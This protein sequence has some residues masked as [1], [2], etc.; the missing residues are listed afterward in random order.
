MKISANNLP[1]QTRNIALS[2]GVTRLL[3]VN[4]KLETLLGELELKSV[5]ESQLLGNARAALSPILEKLNGELVRLSGLASISQPGAKLSL[6][7][8]ITCGVQ[9]LVR[10][11]RG[12]RGIASFGPINAC[13]DELTEFYLD[14]ASD[15][16]SALDP[17][18]PTPRSEPK[19]AA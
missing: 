6:R 16:G 11:S 5:E 2:S 8:I 13:V 14:F 9:A 18:E 7:G 19:R 12:L 4:R 17:T 1:H 10:E 15:L 3:S